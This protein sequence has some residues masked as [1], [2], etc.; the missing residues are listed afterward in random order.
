MTVTI[1]GL[2]SPYA[3]HRFVYEAFHG[4]LDDNLQVDHRNT[5]KADNNIGN[6]TALTAR[7]HSIN[8][9]RDN[10]QMSA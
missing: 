5:A 2:S 6:L 10:P 8:T 4:L 9:R 3:L 1:D 7:A